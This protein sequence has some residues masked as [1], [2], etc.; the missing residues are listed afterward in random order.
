MGSEMCIR[1]REEPEATPGS[2]V[3]DEHDKDD[4]TGSTAD[5]GNG[6][7]VTSPIPFSSGAATSDED[8]VSSETD[9]GADSVDVGAER[10]GGNLGPSPTAEDSGNG[11]NPIC[12]AVHHISNV[13][14]EH[15]VFKTDRVTKVLCDLR[16]SSATPGHMVWYKKQPMMMA[17]CTTRGS[18][19]MVCCE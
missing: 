16:D 8:D 10:N 3:M 2:G 9:T 17:S 7:T 1:D 6:S 19:S 14:R 12:V 11:D 15:L 13:P 5:E 18:R 4:D